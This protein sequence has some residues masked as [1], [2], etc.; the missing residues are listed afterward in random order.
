MPY[1]KHVFFCTNNKEDGSACCDRFNSRKMR[2]Y[3]KNK[4]KELGILGDDKVR[5]NSAGCLGKCDK[6]PV[7]VIYPEGTWYTWI[8]ELDID[9]IITS[10]LI[11]NKPV[12]RLKI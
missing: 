7:V 11:D 2:K 5:I 9:E 3:A 10:H 6:G 4:A 1:T 8:D 12:K